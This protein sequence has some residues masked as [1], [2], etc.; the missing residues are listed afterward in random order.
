MQKKHVWIN[1]KPQGVINSFAVMSYFFPSK[2]QNETN[3]TFKFLYKLLQVC[4]TS[5]SRKL[6]HLL[7]KELCG[8]GM[9]LLNFYRFP[10]A[11]FLYPFKAYFKFFHLFFVVFNTLLFMTEMEQF[12]ATAAADIKFSYPVQL[13][14]TSKASFCLA[15]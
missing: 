4:S 5:D 13:G 9:I 6:V 12:P 11:V 8:K 1:I 2:I 10:L 3:L 14:T 7:K 15:K